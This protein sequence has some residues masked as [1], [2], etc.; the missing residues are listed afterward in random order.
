MGNPQR[1]FGKEFAVEAVRLVE[2]SGRYAK[3]IA[4]DLSVGLSTLR[5]WLDKRREHEIEAPPLEDVG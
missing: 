4:R 3:E 5:R 2:V 1:R